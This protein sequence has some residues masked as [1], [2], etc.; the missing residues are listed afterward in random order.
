[1]LG[2][3]SAGGLRTGGGVEGGGTPLAITL[4]DAGGVGADR[5]RALGDNWA[6][7][8][9]RSIVLGEGGG[10]GIARMGVLG[11]VGSI[12]KRGDVE[13]GN[14]PGEARVKLRPGLGRVTGITGWAAISPTATSPIPFFYSSRCFRF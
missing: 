10:G 9:T 2:N 5:I 8:N 11:G 1:M 6:G 3:C 4:G 13:G 12:I 7:G 14:T